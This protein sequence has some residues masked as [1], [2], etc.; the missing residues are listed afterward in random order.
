MRPTEVTSFVIN[1]HV[2][3]AL[4]LGTHAWGFTWGLRLVWPCMVL[5]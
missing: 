2:A 3:M 5:L 4:V 1:E